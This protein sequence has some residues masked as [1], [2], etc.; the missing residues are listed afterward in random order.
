MNACY[1]ASPVGT[2]LEHALAAAKARK[3]TLVEKPLARCAAEAQQIIGVC[4][5]VCVCV[6]MCMCVCLCQCLCVYVTH[7]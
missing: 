5:C 6:C 3:P 1:I 4:V 2:H 7:I